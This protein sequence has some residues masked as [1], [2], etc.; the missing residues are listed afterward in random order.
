MFTDPDLQWQPYPSIIDGI[1]DP[2]AINK[3]QWKGKRHLLIV[4]EHP[5]SRTSAGETRR[6][7]AAFGIVIRCDVY[8]AVEEMLYSIM[9]HGDG[10]Q[11]TYITQTHSS[12]LIA[13]MSSYHPMLRNPEIIERRPPRHFSFTG[14]DYCYETFG[15]DEPVIHQFTSVDEGYAWLPGDSD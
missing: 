10:W 11:P 2:F 8:L 5:T 7:S 4:G 13:A 3:G 1:S 9:D 6:R 12:Q 14:N 15:F